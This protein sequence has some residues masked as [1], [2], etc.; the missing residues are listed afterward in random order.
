[1]I[2]DQNPRQQFDECIDGLQAV[3]LALGSELIGED[4]LAC[5]VT[6][7][8]HSLKDAIARIEQAHKNELESYANL[9]LEQTVPPATAQTEAQLPSF[10]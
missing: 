5:L 10:I 9:I 6:N 4:S 3:Q 8:V 7:T 1:M 2:Y